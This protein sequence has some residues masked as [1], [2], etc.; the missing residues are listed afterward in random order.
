MAAVCEAGGRSLE[1]VALLVRTIGP[2]NVTIEGSAAG[3]GEA[4]SAA[5]RP[6]R[7]AKLA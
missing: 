2:S 5:F 6:G 1:N 3:L 7:P 4:A